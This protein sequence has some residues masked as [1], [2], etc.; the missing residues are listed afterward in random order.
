LPTRYGGQDRT[1]LDRYVVVEELVAAGAPAGAHWVADQQV[2]PSLVRFGTE[3]QREE[4]LPGI[5]AGRLYFGVAV[6]EPGA[7]SDVA[8]VSTHATRVPGGWSISGS[9]AWVSGVRRAHAVVLLARTEPVEPP[10]RH[11]G[12]SQF[13]VRTDS[14]GLTIRPVPVI[15]QRD[16]LS[17]LTL[18]EVFVPDSMVLGEL[19]AGWTQVTAQLAVERSGPEQFMSTFPLL[20]AV[21][22]QVRPSGGAELGRLVARLWTLRQMSLGVAGALAEPEPPDLAA[23]LVKDRGTR[24][25]REVLDTARQLL[26]PPRA[27]GAPGSGGS[28]RPGG[29]VLPGGSGGS[30]GSAGSGGSGGGAGLG[31]RPVDELLADAVRALPTFTLRGGTNEVLRGIVARGLGLR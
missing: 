10:H 22:G 1:A 28:A 6:S 24:F 8:S 2:G 18:R 5:A 31:G 19:G 27:G 29:P 14:P 30:G 4:L 23:A 15:T 9:K 17:Q 25:E 7:G 11:A 26:G 21:L 13:I 20:R 3:W 16:Q 12:L